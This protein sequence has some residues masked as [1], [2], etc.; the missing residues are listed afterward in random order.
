MHPEIPPWRTMHRTVFHSLILHWV[1]SIISTLNVIIFPTK[2]KHFK[3]A[4]FYLPYFLTRP[5]SHV[6]IIVQKHIFLDPV[7]PTSST[8]YCA[9]VP[10]NHGIIRLPKL[11][12]LMSWRLSLSLKHRQ[13]GVLF[14]K[15]LLFIIWNNLYLSGGELLSS[16][17]SIHPAFFH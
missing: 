4:A 17:Q 1:G 5:W 6:H 7:A 16:L 2:A 11:Q 15:F 9:I 3:E 12:M 10:L 14:M 13:C 8:C